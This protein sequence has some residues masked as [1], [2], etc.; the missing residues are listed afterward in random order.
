MLFEI[1]LMN[2]SAKRL[3]NGLIITTC[4]QDGERKKH[5]SHEQFPRTTNEDNKIS[6]CFKPKGHFVGNMLWHSINHPQIDLQ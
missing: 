5:S 2:I 6:R 3:Y 1:I 4:I